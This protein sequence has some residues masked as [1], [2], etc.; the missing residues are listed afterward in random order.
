[1]HELTTRIQMVEQELSALRQALR[2]LRE[3]SAEA[4]RVP[5]PAAPVAA[6]RLTAAISRLQQSGY[7]PAMSERI[8][9]ALY[10]D[11]FIFQAPG[12]SQATPQPETAQAARK[13]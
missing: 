9:Q 6:P 10:S 3:A 13:G 1:M 4:D 7:G 11:N 5:A 12:I 2:R 8:A